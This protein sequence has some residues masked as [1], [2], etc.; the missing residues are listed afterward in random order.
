MFIKVLLCS[1]PQ[2]LLLVKK[3]RKKKENT[4]YGFGLHGHCQSSS[5]LG[6]V[7]KQECGTRS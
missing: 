6:G 4:A 3:E 1:G 5:K 2:T 7:Y